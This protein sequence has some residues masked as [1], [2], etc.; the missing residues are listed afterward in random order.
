[1]KGIYK[2]IYKDE[3]VYIGKSMTNIEGRIKSHTESKLF[4][5]ATMYFIPNDSDIAILETY[6]IS[7]YKPRCN[8][9]YNYGGLPSISIDEDMYLNNG[10]AVDYSTEANDYR[11]LMEYNKDFKCIASTINSLIREGK[12]MEDICEMVKEITE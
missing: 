5:T 8:T 7:K 2:L 10:K 1:M 4:D 6:L 3:L 11:L 12:S 9:E